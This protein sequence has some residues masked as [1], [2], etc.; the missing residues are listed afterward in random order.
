MNGCMR[1]SILLLLD[2]IYENTDIIVKKNAWYTTIA[3]KILIIGYD[4]RVAES[5][6]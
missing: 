1:V 3:K 5:R 6:L 2:I 4:N